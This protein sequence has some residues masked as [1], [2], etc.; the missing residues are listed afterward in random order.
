MQAVYWRDTEPAQLPAL[1]AALLSS[2]LPGLLDAVP[3]YGSLY[4][5]FEEQALPADTLTEWL[6]A[7]TPG[8]AASTGRLVEI[9][10]C[11]DG[12]DLGAAAEFSGLSVEEVAQ[13]HSSQTYRVRALGFVAGFPFMETT[14]PE[15][16]LPRRASPRAKVPPHS[17]AV[18]GAQT[19]IYPVEAPGGWNLLGRTLQAAYDPHREPAFLVQPGDRV[20]FVPQPAGAPLLP[21]IEPLDLLPEAPQ[22]PALEVGQ[23]G[24]LSLVMDRGRF[25][26]GRFGL[27]RSGPLD[28]QAAALANDLLGNHPDAPLLELHLR[29]PELSALRDCSLAVTGLGLT[30]LVDGQ[31]QPPYSTFAVQ[32]GQRVSFRPS[33]QGR[34][35]YLAIQSGFEASTFMDSA[36]TDLKGG[37][38]QKLRR[39]QLLGTAQPMLAPVR[40]RQFLPWWVRAGTGGPLHLRL[41]PASTG[42]AAEPALLGPTYRIR[43]LDRMG[44]RL[45]GPDAPGGEITSEGSPVGTVQLPPGGQPIILLN[46]KG[47]LGGYRRG[48]RVH[49]DDLPRLVQSGP[50]REIRFVADGIF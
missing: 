30:A 3:A 29:G 19:G 38:G 7:W 26:A 15:L 43:E 20:R 9:P 22:F 39:G 17:L 16:Q 41:I 5:E 6:A 1:A 23:P 44:A 4:V 10:V 45:D 49:P 24:A 34:V 36:S 42:E 11:Y 46:D 18:A 32:A 31:P 50:D 33:G 27:V 14:P 2:G 40:S 47:T 21:P 8:D 28:P 37:L 12:E 25:R 35:T 13:R 48:G